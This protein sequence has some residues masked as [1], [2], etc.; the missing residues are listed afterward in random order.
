MRIHVRQL[1][2]YKPAELWDLLTGEFELEFDD[3]EVINTNY[4]E[5]IYS[6]YFWD[7]FEDH[8]QFDPLVEPKLDGDMYGW[9]IPIVSRYHVSSVLK[10]KPLDAKT[11]ITLSNTIYWDIFDYCDGNVD[12]NKVKIARRIYE[13]VNELYNGLVVKLGEH[14]TS[15]CVFDLL[16]IYQHPKIKVAREKIKPTPE[17]IEEG[18]QEILKIIRTEPDLD[19]NPGCQMVRANISRVGN[20]LQILSARGY[21]TDINS[22]ILAEPIMRGFLEGLIEL[23]DTLKESRSA[24]KALFFASEPL[25]NVEYSNRRLKMGSAYVQRLHYGDCGTTSYLNWL[26]RDNGDNSIYGYRDLHGLKGKWY[27][28]EDG[29]KVIEGNEKHLIGKV[30]KLRSTAK[31]NHPDTQGICSVCYGKLSDSVMPG[32]NIGL[33][34]VT[35]MCRFIAQRVLST[36]HYDGSSRVDDVVM[37]KDVEWLLRADDDNSGYHL[38]PEAVKARVKVVLKQAE[39]SMLGDI[40]VVPNTNLLLPARV[41][42]IVS[43]SLEFMNG[44]EEDYIN[45]VT[46]EAHGRKPYLSAEAL[47]YIREHQ[48]QTDRKNNFVIDMSNWDPELPFLVLPFKQ[49]NMEDMAKGLTDEIEGVMADADKRG[50]ELELDTQLIKLYDLINTRL[51]V[52][53]A[54]VETIFYSM[55]IKNYAED[56]YSLPKNGEGG[57]AVY[58]KMMLYRSAGTAMPYERQERFLYRISSYRVRNRPDHPYDGVLMPEIIRPEDMG[59]GDHKRLLRNRR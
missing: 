31:C 49:Y 38:T 41:S 15:L 19:H 6:R 35:E 1:M 50:M 21:L 16:E 48:W 47:E 13:Q 59:L 12:D 23:K 51:D 36:K 28:T 54:N 55:L 33:V 25:Q 42:S 7:V 5:T 43:L 27:L 32:S 24:S 34:S 52:N 14:V 11:H 37:D 40:F 57:L 18:H 58:D 22:F 53:L 26:V 3:G 17:S 20:V 2:K 4:K 45:N 56:D 44:N 10:G 39:V 46:V 8:S 29:L 30:I 9:E